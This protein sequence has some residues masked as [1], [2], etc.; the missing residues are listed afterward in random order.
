MARGGVIYNPDVQSDIDMLGFNILNAGSVS[1]DIGSL[2]VDDDVTLDGTLTP[3]TLIGDVNNYS[4][5][6]LSTSFVL[7]IDGGS[8]DRNITGIN[9]SGWGDGR[10]IGIVNIGSH[11]LVL[12][13]QSTNS[14]VGNRFLAPE[15][16]NLPPNAAQIFRYD[17]SEERR[18]GKE[19]RSRWS[20]YH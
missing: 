6:G 10:L 15:D 19:C 11:N 18:V 16:I 9:A 5:T 13:N 1:G 7:R 20:P 14:L 2:K 8:S 4:P 12:K 17:R 3:T